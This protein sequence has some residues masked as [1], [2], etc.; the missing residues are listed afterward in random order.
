MEQ[1]HITIY[2]SCISREP[3]NQELLR[4]GSVVIDNYIQKNSIVTLFDDELEIDNDDV[5]ASSNFLKRMTYYDFT[6]KAAKIL[7]EQISDWLI[8]DFTEL[9]FGI[10]RLEFE[11]IKTSLTNSDSTKKT[12]VSLQKTEKYKSLKASYDENPYWY[13]MDVLNDYIA[14]FKEFITATYPKEKIILLDTHNC[15]EYIGED[16]I[17]KTFDELDK[18]S[19]ENYIMQQVADTF[20]DMMN[21]EILRIRLPM[22]ITGDRKH[23]LGLHALHYEDSCYKYIANCFHQCF[24][25]NIT[26]KDLDK[27]YQEYYNQLK[28]EKRSIRIKT[29]IARNKEKEENKN[30]SKK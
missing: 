26:Q 24:F 5:I 7:K 16:G 15:M 8:I 23:H 21:K 1:K 17:L 29:S 6:K 30:T 10:I 3:F 22:D 19:R 12:V 20:F 25:N 9:R 11:G 18:L 14:K 13:T 27:L 28:K 2:G 4:D